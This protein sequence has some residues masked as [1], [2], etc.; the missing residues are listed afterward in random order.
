MLMLCIQTAVLAMTVN[1]ANIRPTYREYIQ[2]FGPP[3]CSTS[4]YCQREFGDNSM[5]V[6]EITIGRVCTDP[7]DDD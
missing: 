1:C 2:Q 7:D 4:E 5:C 3:Y 6:L